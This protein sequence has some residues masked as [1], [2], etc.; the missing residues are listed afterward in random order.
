MRVRRSLL[1]FGVLVLAGSLVAYGVSL[2]GSGTT[3]TCGTFTDC[4]STNVNGGSGSGS[5]S[6][7]GGSGGG[8]SGGPIP[9]PASVYV[10][11]AN[12]NW[13]PFNQHP[14]F[15]KGIHAGSAR[16]PLAPLS[17][18]ACSIDNSQLESY[19]T[20]WA[21][22]QNG[23]SLVG[24][25]LKTGNT[26]VSL[27]YLSAYGWRVFERTIDISNRVID[28]VVSFL[29]SSSTKNVSHWVNQ[30]IY[31]PSTNSF[32]FGNVRSA[33]LPVSTSPSGYYYPIYVI[34]G[35]DLH[36][37][38]TGCYVFY[39]PFMYYD[40]TNL[41]S[42]CLAS[43]YCPSSSSMVRITGSGLCYLSSTNNSYRIPQAPV[44]VY[45]DGAGN[46]HLLLIDGALGDRIVKVSF[47]VAD[48]S[49][50]SPKING[51]SSIIY[52]PPS[53][54]GN[55]G[56]DRTLYTTDPSEICYMSAE[57]WTY[58]IRCYTGLDL[59][60]VSFTS[61]PSPKDYA[62]KQA[63]GV[64]P[65]SSAVDSNGYCHYNIPS[66]PD[67]SITSVSLYV[68]NMYNNGSCPTLSSI[69]FW[70]SGQI[71]S[72]IGDHSYTSATVSFSELSNIYTY[73]TRLTFT[74]NKLSNGYYGVTVDGMGYYVGS[75][76]IQG[77][78]VKWD[79]YSVMNS[80]FLIT[81]PNFSL[82]PAVCGW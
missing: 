51:S 56:V 67:H 64:S 10:V 7:G 3:G 13:T 65:T 79:P 9:P 73:L 82:N 15:V 59:S 38:W 46:Y 2:R 40:G 6:G 62:I 18:Y 76:S 50:T 39:T 48:A 34:K 16:N 70:G 81:D 32:S 66:P 28:S 23:S 22:T 74:N 14:D 58:Y 42:Y 4:F 75:A 33:S 27:N 77:N 36:S 41:R 5:G 26:V 20:T 31:D 35:G 37:N 19:Q 54:L 11:D 80:M 47:S 55:D 8:G 30:I 60:S 1:G 78:A 71:I 45:K 29:Y 52:T 25:D 12:Y 53:R 68:G 57:N 43:L 49:L 21:Y 24:I 61:T 69:N 63:G 17:Y 72:K 44:G